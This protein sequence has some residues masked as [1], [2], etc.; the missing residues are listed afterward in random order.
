MAKAKSLVEAP[1]A[2]RIRKLGV[3]RSQNILAF[4]WCAARRSLRRRRTSRRRERHTSAKLNRAIHQKKTGTACGAPTTAMVQI[5]ACGFGLLALA[6]GDERFHTYEK[7]KSYA[8]TRPRELRPRD[9]LQHFG[10]G[11]CLPRGVHRGRNAGCRAD[12]LR[13]CGRQTFS[14]WLNG[15][16]VDEDAGERSAVLPNRDAARRNCLFSHGNGTL[17]ELSFGCGHGERRADRRSGCK[18]CGDARLRRV[19]AARALGYRASAQ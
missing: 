10:S 7:N 12:K 1:T 18:T 9:Y 2:R 13:A 15:K 4:V 6:C 5:G 3:T 16:Q 19:R 14:T 11:L 8:E 17:G